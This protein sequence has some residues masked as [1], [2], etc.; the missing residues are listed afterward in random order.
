MFS[1]YRHKSDASLELLEKAKNGAHA[2]F[3]LKQY[4]LRLGGTVVSVETLSDGTTIECCRFKN[5]QLAWAAHPATA[6]QQRCCGADGN[7][8]SG[9]E[10]YTVARS[11]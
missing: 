4:S 11:K 6:A 1:I 2:F 8:K 9:Q 7:Y 10:G 3:L 5:G